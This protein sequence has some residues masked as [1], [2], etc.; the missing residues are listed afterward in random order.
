MEGHICEEGFSAEEGPTFSYADMPTIFAFARAA[1]KIV[2][3]QTMTC[4]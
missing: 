3:N 2:P 1:R 4:K